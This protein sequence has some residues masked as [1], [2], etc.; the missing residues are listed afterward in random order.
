[1]LKDLRTDRIES[2]RGYGV[3]LELSSPWCSGIKNRLSK[4]ALPLLKCRND[5]E[6]GDAGFE[7]R[8]VVIL[9]DPSEAADEL[10]ARGTAPAANHCSAFLREANR[11]A[12][13]DARGCT[14][15][16][17]H[18]SVEC[19]VAH[20]ST[21]Y[22]A[23]PA[24]SIPQ[25]CSIVNEHVRRYRTATSLGLLHLPVSGRR[26]KTPNDSVLVKPRCN[27]AGVPNEVVLLVDT[28]NR[29]F[30]PGNAFAAERVLAR[31]GYRVTTPEPA[32]GRPLCC[33]RT[34]LAAGLV[35]EARKEARRMLDAAKASYD[36]V[37]VP[38]ALMPT[39]RVATLTVS[40]HISNW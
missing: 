29:Y 18:F 23:R 21:P 30:E 16:E 2:P 36:V 33:G 24:R 8:A 19:S 38:G 6:A 40:P 4:D 22:R 39:M 27:G 28:F 15:D 25:K 12:L 1:V 10:R 14:G 31:A 3:V 11:H 32:V 13:S 37:T 35:D 9:V 17:G 5:T 7:A 26:C 34:F 20:F